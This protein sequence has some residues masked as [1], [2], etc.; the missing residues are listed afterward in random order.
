MTEFFIVYMSLLFSLILVGAVVFLTAL[1]SAYVYKLSRL[2]L[3]DTWSKIIAI[4]LMVVLFIFYLSIG[5]YFGE[6]PV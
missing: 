4:A 3:N 2:V 6:E 1:A 5:V